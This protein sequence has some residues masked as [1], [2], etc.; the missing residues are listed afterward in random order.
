MA[1]NLD[2]PSLDTDGL[3]AQRWVRLQQ[4]SFAKGERHEDNHRDF[5]PAE[6]TSAGRIVPQPV[7]LRVGLPEFVQR[8][9]KCK[10]E[11]KALPRN[12]SRQPWK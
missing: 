1:E 5:Q 7:S 8:P 9:R 4:Q 11:S 3:S 6:Q 10:H 12:M 2:A